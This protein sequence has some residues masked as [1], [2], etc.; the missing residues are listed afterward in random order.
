MPATIL[1]EI[2]E[3]RRAAVAER[4]KAVGTLPPRP[5]AF[6]PPKLGGFRRAIA[7][8][9]ARTP[10]RFLCELKKASPSKG[11]ARGLRP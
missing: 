3:R 7:R 11:V 2:A 8:A 6:G 1:A 10:L 5:P 9:D 4:K